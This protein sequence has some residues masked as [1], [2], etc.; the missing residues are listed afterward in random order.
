MR[1][2]TSV[3]VFLVTTDVFLAEPLASS[4]ADRASSRRME[5]AHHGR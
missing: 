2:S 4:T 3:A 5:H 1:S